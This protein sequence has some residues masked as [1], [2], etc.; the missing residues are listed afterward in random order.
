MGPLV[1]IPDIHTIHRNTGRRVL[2]HINGLNLSKSCVLVP[3][4]PLL[5][6]RTFTT[7]ST[8]VGI[9]LGGLPMIFSRQLAHQVW[10]CVLFPWRTSRSRSFV[11]TRPAATAF[12]DNPTRLNVDASRDLRQERVNEKLQPTL[13]LRDPITSLGEDRGQIHLALSP[14]RLRICR[15]SE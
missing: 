5:I 1:G 15:R 8:I 12:L 11:A 10:V 13:S 2:H 3:V 4:L 9:P 7:Q 14:P 6:T